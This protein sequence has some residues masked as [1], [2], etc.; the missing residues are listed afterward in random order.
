MS[1]KEILKA[2]KD[3]RR[4]Q[5]ELELLLDSKVSEE[6]VQPT[7]GKFDVRFDA[8]IAKGGEYSRDPTNKE[9]RKVVQGHNKVQKRSKKY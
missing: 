4:R 7:E 1:E 6:V 8:A 9:Y 3:E 2:E 5:A